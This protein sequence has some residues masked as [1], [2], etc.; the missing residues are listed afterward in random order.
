M[1]GVDGCSTGNPNAGK[2]TLV[3]ETVFLAVA[4]GLLYFKDLDVFGGMMHDVS[5][6]FLAIMV[7]AMP[8]M[9]IG[10]LVGGLIEAF[11]SR[12]LVSRALVGRNHTAVFIAAGLG[13]M[14]PVCDCAIV[15]V[16]RRLLGKGVPL[17]AGIAFLLA[18]PIV[19]PVV[20][21][22]TW[23]AYR[24]HWGFLATRMICG[25]VIAVTVAMVMHF[26]F[27]GKKALLDEPSR[28]DPP[29]CGCTGQDHDRDQ[30][31]GTMP[32]LLAAFAHACDDFFNVGK[33]LVI[34]AFVA[35]VARTYIGVDAVRD[36]FSTPGI[37]IILMM[38]LA[39]A[40]NLC[41]ETDAFIAAGFRG[42]LPDTAQMAFMVLGPMLDFKMV[43]MYLTIF[44]K[45][46]IGVLCLLVL[47]AVFVS[48]MFLQYGLGGV[49]GGR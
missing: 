32:R 18:G 31:S 45:R 37:A 6:S 46:V 5:I 9:L 13:V 11:V 35:A 8:F 23:L 42:V 25:Y 47:S 38:G 12:D 4:L 28:G 39:V 14:F 49:P 15:P 30:P 10:S 16:V 44:P 1:H 36:L 19:N 3:I 48:M 17:S 34:G 33:F 2:T 40:L 26:A 7:E 24:F 43:L 20:A 29:G 27:Q 41:S 21:A 22:S